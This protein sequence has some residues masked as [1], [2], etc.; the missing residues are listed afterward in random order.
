MFQNDD[1]S[2]GDWWLFWILMAIPIVNVI[3]WLI[4]LFS[5]STNRTLKHMLW[6][7]VLIVVI[8]IALFATLL[9]PVWSQLQ[10]YFQELIQMIR[11][12]LPY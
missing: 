3:V 2:I 6:A 7:E 10:P 8:I 11:S 12:S 9:A 5:S 1:L 4:I